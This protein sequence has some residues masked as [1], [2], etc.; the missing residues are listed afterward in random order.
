MK[1]S[2]QFKAF[3][4]WHFFY[5]IHLGKLATRKRLRRFSA[6]LQRS[7]RLC[8]YQ[9]S[10]GKIAMEVGTVGNGLTH[11]NEGWH[12]STLTN[13]QANARARRRSL[14]IF[15]RLRGQ[16]HSASTYA[17]SLCMRASSELPAK[18]QASLRK[19]TTTTVRQASERRSDSAS[20]RA[21]SPLA[22]P[23]INSQHYEHIQMARTQPG[24]ADRQRTHVCACEGDQ[25]LS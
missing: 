8:T 16:A 19:R 5:K 1:Q 18:Q 20:Q 9:K 25:C 24:V 6:V 21:R 14:R 7:E 15:P 10:V 22:V 13:A 4:T 17:R 3:Q 23:S 12:N 2:A 11:S